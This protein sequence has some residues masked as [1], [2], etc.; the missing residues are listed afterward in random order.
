MVLLR[1]LDNGPANFHEDMDFWSK[2]M[3]IG[4]FP[5]KWH[6]IK[7]ICNFTLRSMMLQNNENKP[8]TSKDPQ[9]ASY[10]T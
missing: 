7:D 1:W 2:D 4:S 5:V 6:I 3:W 10:Y 8:V 9:E